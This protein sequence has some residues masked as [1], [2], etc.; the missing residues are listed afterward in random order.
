LDRNKR[1]EA[2]LVHLKLSDLV[3][4]LFMLDFA[5]ALL[6]CSEHCS[7]I[8]MFLACTGMPTHCFPW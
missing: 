4:P 5:N 6:W 8:N 7:S 3:P 2:K 1:T